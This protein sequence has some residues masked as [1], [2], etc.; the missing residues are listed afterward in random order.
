MKIHV[1]RVLPFVLFNALINLSVL[2]PV[3]NNY[4]V[5]FLYHFCF[6]DFFFNHYLAIFFLLFI[7]THIFSVLEKKISIRRDFFS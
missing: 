3:S 4:T 2:F 5:V 6:I 7:L 1:L